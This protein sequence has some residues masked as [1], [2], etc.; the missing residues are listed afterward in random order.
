MP[1]PTPSN[2]ILVRELE[3]ARQEAAFFRACLGLVTPHDRPSVRYSVILQQAKDFDVAKMCRWLQVSESGY[4]AWLKRPPSK[5]SL[6]QVELAIHVKR[7][8]E[9]SNDTYGYRRINAQLAD[10]AISTC[11]QVVHKIMREHDLK[12]CRPAVWRHI[13]EA[14]LDAQPKA[15]LL[16]DTFSSADPG[17]KLCGDITQ[18][19]T[20]EGKG[21][22]ATVIDLFNREVIGW[23]FDDNYRADLICTCIDN[24]YSAGLVDTN[25]V[26]HS[27][28]G[29]QYGSRNFRIRLRTLAVIPSMAPVGSC[30][31]NPVAES[32]FATLKR[33]LSDRTT[34]VSL[35]QARAS[36]TNYIDQWYNRRRLHSALGYQ[37]PRAVRLAYRPAHP[38]KNRSL[39]SK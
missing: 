16:L 4:Y 30:F 28:H 10:E 9:A 25:A 29:S 39:K 18:I 6:R 11:E 13:P 19:D 15:P 27:D 5:R 2:Q 7:V 8:F 14:D 36:I 17:I 3:L 38:E 34:F 31:H 20:N 37:P 35:A 26:F 24:A 33:E 32:F 1:S 12:P 22:L 23:S 21:F